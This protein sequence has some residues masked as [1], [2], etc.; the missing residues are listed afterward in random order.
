MNFKDKRGQFKNIDKL[1]GDPETAQALKLNQP[2]GAVIIANR[3][4]KIIEAD[5]SN[6]RLNQREL[7]KRVDD[8]MTKGNDGV[9]GPDWFVESLIAG[10]VAKKYIIEAASNG[11]IKKDPKRVAAL[12]TAGALGLGYAGLRSLGA[13]A[14]EKNSHRYFGSGMRKSSELP[15]MNNHI[16]KDERDLVPGAVGKMFRLSPEAK[17]QIGK[18]A[19]QSNLDVEYD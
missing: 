17:K 8:I 16:P 2:A 11:W 15:K 4:Q 19:R 1:P 3:V 13:K 9:L 18:A 5:P 6:K 10:F 14:A 12:G 7:K